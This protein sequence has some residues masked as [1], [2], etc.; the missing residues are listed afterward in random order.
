MDPLVG[1]AFVSVEAK[2]IARRHGW[3]QVVFK[4]DSLVLCNAIL[5]TG[6]SPFWTI[7]NLIEDI[8]T[9]LEEFSE[10]KI[11]SVPRKCNSMAHLLAGWAARV[12][13]FGF[14]FPSIILEH[15]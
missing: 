11:A 14:C 8:K 7:A 13:V 4:S 10:W 1:E 3:P 9:R 5:L 6:L 12:G 2:L 15:I